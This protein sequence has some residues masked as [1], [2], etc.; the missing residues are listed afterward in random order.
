MC[1]FLNIFCVILCIALPLF[2]DRFDSEK[3]EV[4]SGLPSSDDVNSEADRHDNYGTKD[5]HFMLHVFSS[6][7]CRI[8]QLIQQKKHGLVAIDG[9][10]AAGKST[11]AKLLKSVYSC[12]IFS[13]DDFFL[14]PVQRTRD[15]L[16]EPGGNIDYE[17]FSEEIIEQLKSGEPFIYRPYDCQVQKL[18]E[19]VIVTPNLLNVVEGVYSL[20]P[21]FDEIYDIKVFLGLNSEEQR[22][23]LLERNP[24]LY[25]RFI[26]EWVPMENKYFNVFQIP[27]KCDF[28]FDTYL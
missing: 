11:L 27:D 17:R 3:V 19:K 20:H 6:L 28:L 14:R 5:V 10:S 15:R 9:N 21:Y 23:R 2:T 7:F 26:E 22:R 16:A 8:D 24:G 25:D 12:N 4:V 1:L 18:A 13:M